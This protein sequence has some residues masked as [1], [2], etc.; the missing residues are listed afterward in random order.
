[1]PAVFE[2]QLTDLETWLKQ[3]DYY[4]VTARYRGAKRDERF[5]LAFSKCPKEVW[6]VA[7]RHKRHLETHGPEETNEPTKVMGMRLELLLDGRWEEW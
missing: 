6:E 7:R 5:P 4:C 3:D 2:E 1:M